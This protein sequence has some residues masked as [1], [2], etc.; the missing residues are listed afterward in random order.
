VLALRQAVL[1]QI[2]AVE[3]K[4][5]ERPSAP[6]TAPIVKVQRVEIRQTVLVGCGELA[7]DDA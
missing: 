6:F 4:E 5:I 2:L 7:I 1:T 3:V